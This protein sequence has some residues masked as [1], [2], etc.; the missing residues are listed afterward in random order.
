MVG[1]LLLCWTHECPGPLA[2][3]M[4]DCIRCVRKVNTSISKQ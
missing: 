2:K 1:K 3:E 4:L